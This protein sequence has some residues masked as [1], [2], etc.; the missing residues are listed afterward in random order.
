MEGLGP[1]VRGAERKRLNSALYNSDLQHNKTFMFCLHSCTLLSHGQH[2]H[3]T[4][5]RITNVSIH[6]SMETRVRKFCIIPFTEAGVEEGPEELC[7]L[8]PGG[9]CTNGHWLKG[10]VHQK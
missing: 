7:M 1:E 4:D 2:I 10:T 5:G 8:T 3:S 6:V 9:K